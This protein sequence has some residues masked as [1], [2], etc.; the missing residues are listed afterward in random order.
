MSQP[1]SSARHVGTVPP[2]RLPVQ[3]SGASSVTVVVPTRN[4][5]GNVG[6][7][8]SRLDSAL[9]GGTAEVLFVDDSDDATP[10]AV[11]RASASASVPVRLIHRDGPARAGG[12]GSA[13]AHGLADS[14][15]TWVVV[16]DGDLQHPP[17]LVPRLV[18]AGDSGALDLVVA[19]RH[20]PGG[21]E[22]GLSGWTRRAVS[23]AAIAV[24]HLVCPALRGIS[25][26][27][28][29]CFAVRRSA[30]DP[31]VL[32]PRGFKILVEILARHPHLRTS[33]L[34]FVM[35][36]RHD[37]ESKASVREGW[38]FLVLLLALQVRRLAP[39]LRFGL[40]G[41]SGILV[42][43]VALALLTSYWAAAPYLLAAALATQVSS[44]WNCA[45]YELAVFT[46]AK[47]GTVWSRSLRSVALNNA[48]L[49]LRLPA[50]ALLVVLGV[51]LL[52][53]NVITLLVM[54]L[55]RFVVSDRW[56]Y[57]SGGS[58]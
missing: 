41:L 52:T 30:V 15:A 45:G 29:G 47:Q 42:N 31:T 24:T 19:S 32:R 23:H 20:V 17:E 8:V 4:E 56:I 43:T 12:L 46:G 49:L 14:E 11:I 10:E 38:N 48:A 18:A 51:G 36:Q 37:G 53:A 9:R 57:V 22:S 2:V 44:A 55:T 6:P 26:P 21:D 33:E 50:L 25:D 13:V 1:V 39:V 3:R 27:M 16:M 5:Q 54:F 40:V 7:L 34:G 58:R 28:S 35:A